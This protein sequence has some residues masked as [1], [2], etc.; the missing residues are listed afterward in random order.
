M[1]MRFGAMMAEVVGRGKKAKLVLAPI[2]AKSL[3][4]DPPTPI[5]IH[6]QSS[7][8]C[9]VAREMNAVDDETAEVPLGNASLRDLP[10]R[11]RRAATA[12]DRTL[13]LLAP[14]GV[15]ELYVFRI[16]DISADMCGVEA[17]AGLA[18]GSVL[19]GVEVIGPN[20]SM[21][22]ADA[23]VVDCVPW[24]DLRGRNR[25]RLRLRLHERGHIKARSEPYDTVQDVDRIRQTI[26]FASLLA[27]DAIDLE[28]GAR[29]RLTECEDAHMVGSVDPAQQ[30][31]QR[32]SLRFEIFAISYEAPV[33]VIRNLNGR[34]VMSLPL[35]LRRRRRR[36]DNRT[37]AAPDTQVRY[38]D[39]ISGTWRER[40]VV[41]L[42]F[43]GL[44][45]RSTKDDVLWPNLVLER[46]QLKTPNRSVELGSLEVRGEE[47]R[48]SICHIA[49]R[50]SGQRA[51]AL[52]DVLL[53]LRHP[54]LE[55]H[56]SVD[57]DKLLTF[58][59]NSKLLAP[60]MK[61]RNENR[62]EELRRNWCHLHDHADHLVRTLTRKR[63]GEVTACVSTVQ[64][65]PG[66]WMGQHM[67]ADKKYRDI[68]PGAL[69]MAY[70][71]Q[72]LLRPDCGFMSFFTSSDNQRMNAIHESFQ[73]L[74]GTPDAFGVFKAPIFERG[75]TKIEPHPDPRITRLRKTEYTMLARAVVRTLGPVVAASLGLAGDDPLMPD[76]A[77]RFKKAGL[78][79]ERKIHIVRDDGSPRLAIIREIAAPGVTFTNLLNMTWLVPL[80]LSRR[81]PRLYIDAALATLEQNDLVLLVP[82]LQ[83]PHNKLK[84][85]ADANYY[86]INRV[87]LRRYAAFLVTNFGRQELKLAS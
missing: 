45:F 77:A 9:I 61:R 82:G 24:V 69:F 72:V 7:E 59:G 21:R 84:R 58:I 36:T 29:I 4:K 32:L 75:E 56:Y 6:S 63:N 13:L 10:P 87:G 19:E 27:L 12:S 64:A 42:S 8:W 80:H 52:S 85:V 15:G 49:L 23:T 50:D 30:L 83:K 48:A 65:W 74:A 20:G 11:T 41:D 46:A 81:N 2:A 5:L 37:T 79:R 73:E 39:P 22:R 17:H 38:R 86:A 31:G 25:F 53:G 62:A 33:R 76:H 26:Q 51:A 43:G 1:E 57:Y 47:S 55:R 68:S 71:D 40:E 67:I 18:P 70:L 35:M 28:T 78:R 44:S 3:P 66:T 60:F 34:V 16:T 54:L 14:S